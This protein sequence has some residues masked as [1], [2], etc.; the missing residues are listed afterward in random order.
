[1]PCPEFLTI[2][3]AWQ[4]LCSKF[5]TYAVVDRCAFPAPLNQSCFKQY[6]QVLTGHGLGKPYMILYGRNGFLAALDEVQY[7]KSGRVTQNF[8]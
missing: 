6:F 1:M 2:S 8:Q 5:L 4:E 3:Q 7:L